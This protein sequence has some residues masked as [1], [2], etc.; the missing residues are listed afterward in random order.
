MRRRF[1]V[2]R[3]RHSVGA[4]L[5]LLR[6]FVPRSFSFFFYLVVAF[7]FVWLAVYRRAWVLLCAFHV[8]IALRA[9]WLSG[10]IPEIRALLGL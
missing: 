6:R 1:V 9:S 10:E 8:R 2:A 5:L 7:S 3:L 4:C